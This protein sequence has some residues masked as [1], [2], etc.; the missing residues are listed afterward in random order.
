MNSFQERLSRK[1]S[2]AAA[3]PT[4]VLQD[5][6]ERRQGPVNTFPL[7]VFHERIRP[8]IMDLHKNYDIPRAYIGACMLVAYS[9]AIG[10]AYAV[11][12]N[13]DE[14]MSLS[15]WACMNGISS[16]GKS[17]AM[18]MCLGPLHELQTE[19]DQ[20]W[21]DKVGKQSDE[22]RERMPLKTIIYRD[23][24][25][26]T[27]IRYIMPHNPKGVLKECD[28]ILEWIN[29][30]NQLSK[31]ESTDEQF[32]LS[33]WN[34]KKYSAIRSSNVKIVIPRVF[35]NILGGIQPKLLWKLFKNERGE[36]GF[37]F[38]VLFA[39]PEDHRIAR[40]IIGHS[41]AVEYKQLYKHHMQTLYRDLPVETAQS[42]PKLCVCTTDALKVINEWEQLKVRKINTMHDVNQMNIHAGILGKIKE[43]TYRFAALLAVGDCELNQ[44]Q[45]EHKHFPDQ[46]QITSDVMRRSIRISDYFY[47]SAVDV[48][49][50]VDTSI[51]APYDVL[52][53]ATLFKQNASLSKIAKTLWGNENAKVKAQRWLKKCITEYP[54]IFGALNHR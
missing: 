46:L 36:S 51:T 34:S 39:Q 38:R 54:T 43:Y 19:L 41:M 23:A 42:E 10:T 53:T 7:D 48:Y 32:W 3:L 52:I 29:G 45:W 16:S 44:S 31:K 30:M 4:D 15:V 18:D 35:A 49:K 27:L 40:P 22:Q 8:F 11:S 5:E 47:E 2:E 26:P 37:I 25:I 21:E 12:R 17:L 9:T 1:G 33:A 24:Y 28:E 14:R 50:Q 6:L 13:G 20:D